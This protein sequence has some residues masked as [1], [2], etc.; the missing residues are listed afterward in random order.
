LPEFQFKNTFPCHNLCFEK[1]CL[2]ENEAEY[3]T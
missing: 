1:T 2:H 3:V